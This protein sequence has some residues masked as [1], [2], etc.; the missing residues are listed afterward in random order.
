MFTDERSRVAPA[1]G[2]APSSSASG[3]Q[4]ARRSKVSRARVRPPLWFVAPALAIYAFIT[5][6]PSGRGIVYAFSDWDGISQSFNLV[7]WV[8]FEAIFTD[9]LALAALRNTLVFAGVVM[10]LQNLLGLLL[11][12]ALNTTVKSRGALRTIFFAPVILTP[13]VTGYIWSYLLAP[14]GAVNDVLTGIGLDQFAQ[15]WLGDPSLALG[16]VIV[17]YLWQFSGFAMVI[18][19][20]GLQ[21]IPAELLEAAAI[22]G[23]GPVR[24]LFAVVLP[25]INGAIVVNLLLTMIN[26]LAQ[27]DQVYAMTQGGPVHATETISTV[28]YKEGFQLGHMPYATALALVMTVIVATLAVAQYRLT[29]RQVAR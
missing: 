4:A 8:N 27:F 7:G 24:R 2:R 26:A 28:I 15:N 3:E 21:A 5:L 1:P 16:S 19:L 12:L 17:A 20:A 9:D 25:M 29:A 23:A 11:A 22:D 10:V 18:Y 13:L 6:W 14:N